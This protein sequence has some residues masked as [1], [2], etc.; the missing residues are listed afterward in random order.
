MLYA[1][2][3]IYCLKEMF[4]MKNTNKLWLTLLLALLVAAL[5][6]VGLTAAAEDTPAIV[7]SGI[8]GTNLTWTLDSEGT[9]TVSG[10]GAMADYMSSE[11]Q[12]P[13]TPAKDP[14][15]WE[16]YD[17][18]KTVVIEEGVT[19]IGEFAFF[20]KESLTAVVLPTGLS[21]VKGGAFSNCS[22]LQHVFF[23]GSAEQWQQVT[24]VEDTLGILSSILQSSLKEATVHYNATGHTPG[25]PVHENEIAATETTAGSYDEVIYCT[26]CSCELS[27]T[28]VTVDPLNAG[29]TETRWKA[30]TLEEPFSVALGSEPCHRFS[31]TPTQ[32]GQ[33]M[34]VSDGSCPTHV[35][36][37]GPGFK[38]ILQYPYT[39]SSDTINLK[40]IAD[41]TAGETYYYL[42]DCTRFESSTA[43]FTLTAQPPGGTCGD[44]VTWVFNNHTLTI[45]GEGAMEDC[46]PYDELPWREYF[47]YRLSKTLVVLEEGVTRIGKYAIP[48]DGYGFDVIVRSRNC[49]LSALSLADS[50]I[51]YGYPGSTAEAY[52]ET[53]ADTCHFIP[54]C[55]T[56]Y[57]HTVTEKA[58]EAAA[59]TAAGHTA[60]WY[61]ED[62][63]GW[64]T[65]TEIAPLNHANAQP[66]A[67]TKPTASA[68]GFTAGVY[69]PDCDTWLSGHDVIHN[70]RGERTVVKEATEDAEGEVIIVCTACGESGLYALEKLP[71]T[72]PQPEQSTDNGSNG[73]NGGED[74]SFFGRLRKAARSII[75]VF[76]RLIRW[77]GGKK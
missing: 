28:C 41:F 76:L 6:A 31:F 33:C 27:R 58:E 37:Y 43:T 77:L 39:A 35:T 26:Q 54:L 48:G 20:A 62:C 52:A 49:D 46:I 59:C 47:Y 38:T 40:L 36:L 23:A 60:G 51:L 57:T 30:I 66:V 2:Q 64:L 7:D 3:I 75:E 56:D 61:C 9:L 15:P 25:E 8:C 16:S 19:T 53:H 13:F 68:H 34:L 32:S 11:I 42:L 4:R 17:S 45:S 73:S 44:G 55:S 1:A 5:V 71:H 50:S 70:Q 22:A 14:A 21:V 29:G 63:G 72:D 10:E 24:I 18:I 74:N 69:C 67:E 12:I 65:G